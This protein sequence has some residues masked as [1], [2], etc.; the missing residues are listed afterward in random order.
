MRQA[1]L[2]AVAILCLSSAC[3]AVLPRRRIEAVVLEA[4]AAGARW[5]I[6]AISFEG[7]AAASGTRA[8][9]EEMLLVIAARRGL[10]L[11][12]SGDAPVILDITV[13][14]RAFDA[15]LQS[16]SSIGFMATLRAR[17][18]GSVLVRAILT[19]ESGGTTASLYYLQGLADA[20]LQ[21]IARELAGAAARG[22]RLAAGAAARG[23]RLAAGA[24][25]K[26]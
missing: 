12:A 24:A 10:P 2:A 16:R 21:R 13:T 17:A 3:C 6:G 11:A 22:K 20:V 25:G 19:E 14:E 1:A 26:G 7:S 5:G 23:K 8:C 18:D 9:L 15:D 4:P